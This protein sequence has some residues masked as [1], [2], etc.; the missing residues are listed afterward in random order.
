M[1]VIFLDVDGVLNSAESDAKAALTGADLMAPDPKLVVRLLGVLQDVPDLVLVLTSTW[2]L[3]PT[4]TWP[5]PVVDVTPRGD[6]FGTRAEEIRG[7]LGE[8]LDV[9]DYAI[10]DDEDDAFFG[11]DPT[12]CVK[13]DRHMGLTSED[14]ARLVGLFT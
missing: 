13:V 9:R 12:V 14:A 6:A 4:I 2:R 1:K 7:W 3:D 5:F 10:L 8:H 11:F